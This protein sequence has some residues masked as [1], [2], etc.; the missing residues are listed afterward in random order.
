MHQKR[1]YIQKRNLSD[2]NPIAWLSM[3]RRS[4]SFAT[5]WITGTEERDE[6]AVPG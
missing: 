6:M 3:E 1:N 5:K 2:P 4:C